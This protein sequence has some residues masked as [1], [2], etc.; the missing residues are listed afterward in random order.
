MD[1]WTR[2]KEQIKRKNTTQ[3]WI[4]AKIEVP[5]GTFRKWLTRKTYPDLKQG[6]EIAGLLD[7]S[8]EYLVTGSGPDI[9]SEEERNLVRNY[10]KLDKADQ[11]NITLAMG[12]WLGKGHGP[13]GRSR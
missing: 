8:V 11:E 1:F 6:L 3:E 2:L 4:A 9:L 12:A 10:R 7:T 13:A 5:F